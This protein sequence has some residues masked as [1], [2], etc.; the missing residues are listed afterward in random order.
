MAEQTTFSVLVLEDDETWAT[1]LKHWLSKPLQGCSFDVTH[2]PT[3]RAASEMLQGIV[4][5]AAILDL[6]LPDSRG[7]ATVA[8]IHAA[9]PRMPVVIVTGQEDED[10]V[11][12]AMAVG[13]QDYLIKGRVSRDLL[14][15]ALHYAIGRKRS[16][17]ALRESEERFR[18]LAALAPA[19]IFQADPEGRCEYVNRRLMEMGG[20]ELAE[21]RGDG[22]LRCI[23]DDD[24]ERVATAWQRFVAS[25]SSW[26][27]EYRL[28]TPQGQMTWV[29]GVAAPLRGAD[30]RITGFVAI[31]TD[32]SEWK[33]AQDSLRESEARFRAMFAQA[34]MGVTLTD[35][36][37]R[38]VNVNARFCHLLGIRDTLLLGTTD[39]AMT[40]PEDRDRARQAYAAL[41]SGETAGYGMEKRYMRHDGSL[42]WVR[43]TAA[44]VT[45]AAGEFEYGLGM[46]EDV[47]ERRLAEAQIHRFSQQLLSVREEEKRRLS[48]MLHHD[49]GSL[50]VGMLARLNAVED[51]LRAGDTDGASLGLLESQALFQQAVA[52]L[53]TLAVELRPPDLDI[54]GLSAALRQ[55][56]GQMARDTGLRIRFV[57]R[58]GDE[59]L[60]R[61][62]AT[63]LFRIV[64]EAVVN[65][66]K[67]AQA[68]RVIV[69][70]GV[71]QGHLQL[72][73]RDD[74]MG[75]DAQRRGS[76]SGQH[77]GL[78]TMQ[79]MAE[80]LRGTLE[81]DACPGGG[82]AVVVRFPNGGGKT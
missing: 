4:F 25:R 51:D 68:R 67:H 22:W 30:G 34:P 74:G 32:I 6:N 1:V 57:D 78:R 14:A 56:L 29:Y 18:T 80:S 12:E 17:D 38:F 15:R 70:L 54:L 76:L 77:L 63:L 52:R 28:V 53:K 11:R 27:I 48:A 59:A 42:V 19:G 13:A 72:A 16:E 43:V 33:R 61:D 66:V 58:L 60:P 3:L 40:A 10:V 75:F 26:S 2:A 20:L 37:G 7:G 23:H 65:T 69:R 62:A 73:I 49:V 47:T 71:A 39:V 81:I 79:E 45:G 64:Q 31:N 35:A 36:E 8:R 9:A 24:R 41:V 44:R 82:T 46:V 50:A 21:A 55:Y 5:D